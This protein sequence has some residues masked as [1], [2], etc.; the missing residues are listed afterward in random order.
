M[1]LRKYALLYRKA[2]RGRKAVKPYKSF[3]SDC[4]SMFSTPTAALQ[5]AQCLLGNI[6]KTMND[7]FGIRCRWQALRMLQI[8]FIYENHLL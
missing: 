5:C 3:I 2:N 1:L 4:S 6:R 8:N 7:P